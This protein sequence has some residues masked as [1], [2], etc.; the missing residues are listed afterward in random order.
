[1]QK[2]H[3]EYIA[4]TCE[5]VA[6]TTDNASNFVKA[7][8]IFGVHPDCIEQEDGFDL[9]DS[10]AASTDHETIGQDI[11][12]TDSEEELNCF[13]FLKSKITLAFALR[14]PYSYTK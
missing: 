10:D 1:M 14:F 3:A 4:D 9:D 11:V 12:S 13:E 2:I 5:I 7:F 6:T 8:R